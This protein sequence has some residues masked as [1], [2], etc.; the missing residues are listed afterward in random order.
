MWC[1]CEAVLH[2]PLI[3]PNT[4]GTANVPGMCKM[5]RHAF[6]SKCYTFIPIVRSCHSDTVNKRVFSGMCACERE[7]ER[8]SEC[9]L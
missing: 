5:A 6:T 9:V 8:E 4:F 3:I 1:G 7:R 2:A